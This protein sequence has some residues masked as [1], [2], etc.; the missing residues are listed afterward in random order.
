MPFPIWYL[1]YSSAE[2]ENKLPSFDAM[3]DYATRNSKNRTSGFSSSS[4][5]FSDYAEIQR[6]I[7][8]NVDTKRFLELATSQDSTVVRKPFTTLM[9]SE[10][11]LFDFY[12]DLT[13]FQP[14]FTV[15]YINELITLGR[16]PYFVHSVSY[17]KHY[18]IMAE[19]DSSRAHLNRTIEKLVAENPLTM[20]EENVLAASKVL[21]YLRTGK[22]E[23]FIEKGE[24]AQEIKNMVSRFNT[25]WKDV[26]HQYDYPLSCTLTS[27]KDYRPLRY[28]QSFDFN[29]KEKK[30]P[31]PQQ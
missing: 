22:K 17:G 16:S 27:L 21:I 30:N 12:T 24:G 6:W 19:S 4:I 11:I 31:A 9:Q 8:N 23:S 5:T 7:P 1:S 29:V 14:Y 2:L 18:I 26:S 28:N 3:K 15:K 25:E 20:Q 10:A 13:D